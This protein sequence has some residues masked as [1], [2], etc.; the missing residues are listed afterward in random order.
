[1]RKLAEPSGPRK[2]DPAPAAFQVHKL[3]SRL[4]SEQLDEIAAR[5]EGGQS[6][7]SLASEFEVAPSALIRL[8]REQN[9]VM[10]RRF[11]TAEMEQEMAQEY[12]AG[13]T[14][15]E[16]EAKHDLS[17]NA[18]LR[19]LHRAGVEMRSTGRQKSPQPSIT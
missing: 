11:V 8:L 9:V 13:M 5:Y 17:H 1:M 3:S 2:A 19:A 12:E 6:A 4:S 7:R 14:V 15:A 10:R 18:A 16:I